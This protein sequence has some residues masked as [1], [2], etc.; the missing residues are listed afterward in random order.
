M[1]RKRKQLQSFGHLMR[2]TESL[3]KTLILGKTEGRRR[4]WKRMRW[5]DGITDSMDRS[6]SNFWQIVKNWEALCAVQWG[7]KESNATQWL[8]NNNNVRETKGN[9]TV[10][11]RCGMEYVT[12]SSL[13]HTRLLGLSLTNTLLIFFP[14]DPPFKAYMK[15][16]IK[17]E[18]W[19]SF[20]NV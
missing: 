8:N 6:L 13:D 17:V 5:L 12:W 11:K 16:H 1:V 18:I 7:H 2:R 15:C 19:A 20:E 10:G 9:T 14:F 3:E 4:G